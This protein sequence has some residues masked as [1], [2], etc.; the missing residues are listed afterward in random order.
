MAWSI[1]FRLTIFSL[2]ISLAIQVSGNFIV[3]LGNGNNVFEATFMNVVSADGGNVSVTTG[4]GTDS[5]IMG[6]ID[7]R[8]AFTVSSGDRTDNVQLE[9]ITSS[10]GSG[11]I[12][13]GAGGDHLI[14]NFLSFAT[15]VLIDSG[16]GDDLVE[17]TQ[18]ES[19]NST[20]TIL[21]GTATPTV[22]MDQVY[23]D[24]LTAR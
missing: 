6:R 16:A 23:V 24:G 3:D 20:I 17:I 13:T 19:V 7:L 22:G 4:T 1:L 11:T 10:N 2:D 21:L 15:A 9:L 14:G 8:N 18:T 12:S 5:I